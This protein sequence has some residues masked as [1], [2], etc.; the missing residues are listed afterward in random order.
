MSNAVRARKVLH[1]RA[2][3]SCGAAGGGDRATETAACW[4]LF[5]G[6]PVS[7]VSPALPTPVLASPSWLP[8]FGPAAARSGQRG[9][10]RTDG[11]AS[12]AALART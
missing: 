2:R 8:A 4:L 12:T 11:P 9:V 7:S 10:A 3:L 6:T 1:P 5:E